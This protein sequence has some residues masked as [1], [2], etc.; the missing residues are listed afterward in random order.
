MLPSVCTSTRTP[1]TFTATSP[2]SS[3]R[4]ISLA[5]PLPSAMTFSILFAVNIVGT[6]SPDET[7]GKPIV[8]AAIEQRPVVKPLDPPIVVGRRGGAVDTA[9]TGT[10]CVERA[11]QVTGVPVVKE[12]FVQF[13]RRRNMGVFAARQLSHR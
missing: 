6:F 4:E 5:L 10:A 3:S 1:F 7:H 2:K 13:L 8:P 12:V 11:A 9:R